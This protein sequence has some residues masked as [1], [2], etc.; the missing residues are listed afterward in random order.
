M[1][2][3]IRQF[4]NNRIKR[5]RGETELFSITGAK[6]RS[7]VSDSDER[8]RQK[9]LRQINCGK[10]DACFCQVLGKH[11]GPAAKLQN[12]HALVEISKLL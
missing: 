9:V 12:P 3:C 1:G 5:I 10:I 11:S 4:P 8:F 2:I 6:G 7:F